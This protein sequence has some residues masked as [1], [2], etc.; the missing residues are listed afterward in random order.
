M[1]QNKFFNIKTESVKPEEKQESRVFISKYANTHFQK[2]SKPE[3]DM[4]RVPTPEEFFFLQTDTAFNAFTFIPLIAK[5]YPIK[6]M[7]AST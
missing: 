7:Y 3:N 6:E 2:V 1:I 4:L 5:T